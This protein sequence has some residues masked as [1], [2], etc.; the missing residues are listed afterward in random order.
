[1]NHDG[2]PAL[3]GPQINH[4]PQKLNTALGP[5]A[6]TCL[7]Q[8]TPPSLSAL[9]AWAFP[10]VPL[11]AFGI[12]SFH[13]N[14]YW[15]PVRRQALRWTPG[16]HRWMNKDP[17]PALQDWKN[18][19]DQIK[20]FALSSWMELLSPEMG[21]LWWAVLGGRDKKSSSF[22]FFRST[23]CFF[24]VPPEYSSTQPCLSIETCSA[25]GALS[26]CSSVQVLF[27]S[28]VQRWYFKHS[29]QV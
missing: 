8:T 4:E 20:C 13:T 18:F 23:S 22:N 24:P 19:E 28:L 1:M 15:V 7:N 5:T 11:S 26:P 16:R 10:A 25:N 17:W 9:K 12:S 21:T 3:S 2:A 14:S 27:Q 29:K 6:R